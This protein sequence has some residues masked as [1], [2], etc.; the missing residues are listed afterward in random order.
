MIKLTRMMKAQ[1]IRTFGGPEVFSYEEVPV[2]EI[3]DDELLVKVATTSYNPSE[4]AARKGAF[5][6]LI[7]LVP[8]KIL[9]SDLAGI[10]H[11][12]GTKVT[13]FQVGDKV[14]AYMNIRSQGTYAQY[15]AIKAK[16]S[17]PVPYNMTL[18]EAG[19]LPL[20]S[21]TAIQGL[22]E[23]GELK[24]GQRVLING[25]AGGVGS[26]ALQM[27]HIIGAYVIATGSDKSMEILQRLD[28]AEIVN[29][30]TQDL[31]AAISEKVDL[32]FNLARLSET[33]MV[34]ML[35][36]V[37]LGGKFVS[38]TGIP[39]QESGEKDNITIIAENSKRG[40]ERLREIKELV[41]NGA[42]FPIITGT[43][44]LEAIPTVHRLAEEGELHGK[45]SIIV[46]ETLASQ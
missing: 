26:Y 44:P 43:F 3:L 6:N 36:L 42:L 21:L 18:R 39:S 16:D 13:G 11:E 37:R 40:G 2:P 12:V 31:Y 25:A 32:I 30:R 7:K 27:A 8:Y 33:E 45:V 29:Y 24:K 15:A 14:F 1:V 20:A 41:E 46:D 17:C 23:L 4:G 35:S 19:V 5:G 10:V 34:R 38:T 9:G 28:P 22:Y